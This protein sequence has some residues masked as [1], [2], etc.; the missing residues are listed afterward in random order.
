MRSSV[1]VEGI[2][3]TRM[4]QML[5]MARY[6]MHWHLCGDMAGNYIK[7]NSWYDNYQR[8]ITTHGTA[9][10]TMFDNVAHR[11]FGHGFYLED[12]IETGTPTSAT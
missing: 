4:G 11:T 8:V 12:G 2:E 3:L 9:N 7:H 10:A 1:R 5:R 6:A